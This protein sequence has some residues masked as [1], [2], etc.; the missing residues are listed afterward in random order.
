MV[1]SVDAISAAFTFVE[2][3]VK[4]VSMIGLVGN[5]GSRVLEAFI[6]TVES[7]DVFFSSDSKLFTF[8]S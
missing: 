7:S 5:D 4:S 3:D 8:M 2:P 6:D 1:S